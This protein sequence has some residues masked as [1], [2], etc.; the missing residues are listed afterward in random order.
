MDELFAI[1]PANQK[2]TANKSSARKLESAPKASKVA[3]TNTGDFT[4]TK[5]V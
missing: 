5:V 3:S 4:F 2:E 1:K